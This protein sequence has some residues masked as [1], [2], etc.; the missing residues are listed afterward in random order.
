MEPYEVEDQNHWFTQEQ[1][2]LFHEKLTEM[3]GS[4]NI[5]R[6][7]GRYAAS[8]E[9]IGVMRQ[10]V[11]GMINPLQAYKLAGKLVSQFSRSA[12]YETKKINSKKIEIIVTPKE[13]VQEQPF[14]CENRMGHFESIALMFN[15]AIPKIE[16]PECIFKG[17]KCC[18]YIISWESNRSYLFKRTRNIIA[19]IINHYQ[20][21]IGDSIS[22]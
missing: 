14:Q 12:T 19:A 7:A 18:R 2:N 10:Y 3:T 13:G 20:R 4:T 21:N 1:I 8:P 5:A 22:G 6:E 9:S 11:L 17:G 15:N 16:H